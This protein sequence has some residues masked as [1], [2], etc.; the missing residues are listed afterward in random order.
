MLTP[1]P[2]FRSTLSSVLSALLAAVSLVVPRAA[3]A[4][5]QD[6]SRFTYSASGHVSRVIDNQLVCSD[7][8]P[9]D[10]DILRRQDGESSLLVIT[11]ER[12]KTDATGLTLIL[13]GTPQLERFP[14]AKSAFL[15]AA[16]AWQAAIRTP[17][18]VVVDVDFGTTRFG[19]PYPD[20]V[21]GSTDSQIIG[22][23]DLYPDVRNALVSGASSS[24]ESALYNALPTTTLPTDLGACGGVFMASSVFRAIGLLPATADPT[25]EANQ[26]GPPPSIGFNANFPFDFDPGN[27]VDSDKFDFNTVVLHEIGHLLGFT[28]D[29]G[30]RELDS[31][32]PVAVST[33]DIFRFRPGTTAGA[34][35]TTSRIL[36]S[37]G[38]QRFFAGGP[39]LAL[40]TGRADGQGGDGQQASH[41]KDD[42]QT[43]VFVG[44]MDPTLDFGFAATITAN[45]LLALDLFGHS[46]AQQVTGPAAPSNLSA[47]QIKRKRVV[48]TWTDNSSDEDGFEVFALQGSDYVSLGTLPAGT[49]A[50]RITR[51]ARRTTYT[52]TV[53]SF[54][55]NGAS[56][57]AAPFTVTT[58]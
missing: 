20:G 2:R 34:F 54:N 56:S 45:D 5:E 25:G 52:F 27:G 41:W 24:Q 12:D 19:T 51:L 13:R 47:S 14:Q 21:L 11:P 4:Q 7:A 40:S 6:L 10:T 46:I 9:E 53:R 43:G 17:I 48:I 37:G 29:V 3:A 32:F 44:L 55:A 18:T 33:W 57:F 50:A 38:E 49:T 23:N 16:A 30:L 15:R 58:K 22:A 39:A 35:G 36:S 31:T 28:S 42:A 1:S 26:L 8:L